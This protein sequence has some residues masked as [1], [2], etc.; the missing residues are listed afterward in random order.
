MNRSSLYGD[1]RACMGLDPWK[2]TPCCEAAATFCGSSL[3]M[4]GLT[5]SQMEVSVTSFANRVSAK[6]RRVFLYSV[7]V[8]ELGVGVPRRITMR[9]FQE[10]LILIPRQGGESCP[11]H[12]P[13]SRDLR[14]VCCHAARQGGQGR[15]RGRGR[16]GRVGRH[17]LNDM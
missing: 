12:H 5:S 16:S 3:S 2:Q 9:D 7:I 15:Q 1:R 6:G 4:P 17:K 11:G 13:A 10:S 8:G 14:D